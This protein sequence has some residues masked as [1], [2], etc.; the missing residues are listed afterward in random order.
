MKAVQLTGI[1]QMDVMEVPDP[2][3]NKPT[4][5]LLKLE[6]VGVCGSDVHYYRTG[7]IGSQVV[8]YPFIVG[9][10]CSAT[11]TEVGSSVTRV[12]VG[13]PVAIEPAMV[14]HQCDQCLSGREN[15]CRELRFLGCPGQSQGC[16]S[17]YIVM[18]ED[19]IFPTE[20]KVTLDQAVLC[21]PLSIGVYAVQQSQVTPDARIAVLGAGPIGLSVLLAAKYQGVEAMYATEKI[22]EREHYAVQAGAQSVANPEREDVIQALLGQEP[23]GYD[24]VYECAGEQ[25]T[26]DQGIEL[27]KPGG[28]LMLVGIP[29]VERI[30]FVIDR[31]RRKEITLINVRRQ[32]HCVQPALDMVASGKVDVDFMI[33]HRYRFDE[34]QAAF[35]LVDEYRDGVVKAMI[36]L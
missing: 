14:C 12:K 28:R 36:T 29:E 35:D 26:I 27:L 22:V 8:E 31:M 1:R 3:I 18:P 17:E 13:D 34:T 6:V 21:E 4:E 10:E 24:V 15:T 23:M 2:R 20:G 32:N 5:I 30:S 19:C 33:T 16:L 9:H 7:R 11:V 25:E